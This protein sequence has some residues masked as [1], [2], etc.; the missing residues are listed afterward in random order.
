[1][2]GR[3]KRREEAGNVGGG[4]S[5]EERVVEWSGEAGVVRDHA[6]KGEGEIPKG[7]PM[8]TWAMPPTAPAKRSFAASDIVGA[9]RSGEVRGRAGW[10]GD[11]VDAVRCGGG[12]RR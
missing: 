5:E 6:G 10:W 11:D 4:G 8:R 3:R 12:G 7:W 9:E 2:R 1:M